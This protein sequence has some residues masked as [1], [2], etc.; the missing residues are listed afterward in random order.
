MSEQ[1]MF[2]TLLH[3]ITTRHQAVFLVTSLEQIIEANKQS[4]NNTKRS[5]DPLHKRVQQNA[6]AHTITSTQPISQCSRIIPKMQRSQQRDFVTITTSTDTRYNDAPA[7]V[8]GGRYL[9]ENQMHS[10]PPKRSERKL[11][12]NSFD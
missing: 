5:F 4:L 1:K 8:F 10:C 3:K 2:I 12:D 6:I 11:V 7:T 9:E